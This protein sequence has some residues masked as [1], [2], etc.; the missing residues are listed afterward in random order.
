M[1]PED[2]GLVGLADERQRLVGSKTPDAHEHNPDA[3]GLRR[4]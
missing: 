4:A 2:D 3:K 1:A